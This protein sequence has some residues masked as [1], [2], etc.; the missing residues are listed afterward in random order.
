MAAVER[1]SLADLSSSLTSGRLGYVL[2]ELASLPRAAVVVED[3]YSQVFALEHVRPAVVA[4]AIAESH[5]RFPQVPIIFTETRPLAQEWTYRFLAAA[6]EELGMAAPTSAALEE[7]S[8]PSPASA[9]EIRSWA[10]ERG[11]VVSDRGRI[12]A[13]V[14]RAFDEERPT[15]SDARP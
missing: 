6:R 4:E 7:L 10:R 15:R 9:G 5:A 8:P 1:K 13:E 11:Y 3:R 12:P 2:A 14:R